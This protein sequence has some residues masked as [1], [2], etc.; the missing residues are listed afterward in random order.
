MRNVQMPQE[1]S[2]EEVTSIAQSSVASLNQLLA[3]LPKHLHVPFTCD[4][5]KQC[6][7]SAI[8]WSATHIRRRSIL[9]LNSSQHSTGTC[10]TLLLAFKAWKYG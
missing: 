2:H 10:A 3:K 4:Y 1:W 8:D 5:L 9:K 6:Q 7:H